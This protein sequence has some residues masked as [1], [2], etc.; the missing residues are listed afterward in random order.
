MIARFDYCRLAWC[1]PA[2]MVVLCTVRPAGAAVLVSESF[3]TDP[4]AGGRA[5]VGGDAARFVR[6]PGDGAL[7]AHYDALLA[8][9]R[10]RW[11]LGRTLTAAD[12]FRFDVDF[13]LRSA[14]FFADPN[15][16]AQIAWGLINAAQTGDDRAGGNAA[17][18]DAFNLTTVDYFP[19]VSPSFGGPTLAPT[20]IQ[21]D[22]GSGFFNRFVFLAGSESLL[23]DA[24]ESPLPLDVP[25][26]A[27]FTWQASTRVAKVRISGPAGPLSINVAGGTAGLPGGPDG[28]PTTIQVTAPPTVD[29]SLDSFAL[30][31]W[32]DS[33]NTA[34]SSLR[35]D[36]A[37][38]GFAVY[39]TLV[40]PEPAGWLLAGTG[41]AGTAL[42]LRRCRRGRG[43]GL[44]HHRWPNRSFAEQGLL[45][46]ATAQALA[47][48]SSLR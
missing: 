8:T 39:D 5:V 29:F 28:D 27:S 43:R 9:S 31:L 1:A 38:D 45:S 24:G 47:V 14:G 33:F 36:V 20:I 30:T 25:L 22:D 23:D 12:D 10:L 48:Q 41:L 42:A 17:V 13:T 4:V 35:A 15:Q 40:V 18:A 19:N 32:Q 16:F 21:S 34:G 3:T 7:S 37:F 26:V 44:D 2:M 11:P 46:L 6:S